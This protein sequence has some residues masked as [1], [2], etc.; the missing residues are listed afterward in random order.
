MVNKSSEKENSDKVNDSLLKNIS[1]KSGNSL[2]NTDTEKATIALKGKDKDY[3]QPRFK[4]AGKYFI[5]LFSSIKSFI[6]SISKGNHIET[7]K[8]GIETSIVL[9]EGLGF[10]G[11]VNRIRDNK[12]FKNIANSVESIFPKPVRSL[13]SIGSAVFVA[14]ATGGIIAVSGLLTALS[15]K[16]YSIYSDIKN[17]KK[18]DSDIKELGVIKKEMMIIGHKNE[19]LESMKS[20]NPNIDLNKVVNK[21]HSSI[22]PFR[23]ESDLYQE[24]KGVRKIPGSN[25]ILSALENSGVFASSI[26]AGLAMTAITTFGSTAYAEMKAEEIQDGLND[27]LIDL[28]TNLPYYKN[29]KDL[30]DQTNDQFILCETLK[31]LNNNKEFLEV[32]D[33]KIALKMLRDKFYSIKEISSNII[34]LPKTPSNWEAF[35]DTEN[36]SSNYGNISHDNSISETDISVELFKEKFFSKIKINRN[37]IDISNIK[38]GNDITIGSKLEVEL[39]IFEKSNHNKNITQEK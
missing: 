34:D 2:I 19:I 33:E 30:C 3:T 1:D 25:L 13:I 7:I 24:I 20:S 9:T 39:T 5:G 21:F 14:T 36:R 27:Q 8:T 31:E 16:A 37:N 11:F 18:L 10:G 12:T 22:V 28:K 6:G 38:I 4:K 23:D 35:F 29:L 15:S 26:S 17:Y 32:K